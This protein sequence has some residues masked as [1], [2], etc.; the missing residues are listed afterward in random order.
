M[1]APPLSLLWVVPA[2]PLL[3]FVVNSTLALTRPTAKG[4]VSIVGVGVAARQKSVQP[5]AGM[6]TS[7]GEGSVGEAPQ[8]GGTTPI[9]NAG[10]EVP[11]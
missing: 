2:L 9:A 1:P 6:L 11:A 4:A 3:G 5:A 8:I 10:V 7:A